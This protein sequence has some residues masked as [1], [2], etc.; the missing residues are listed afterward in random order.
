[1][2][3]N[4][5]YKITLLEWF[6]HN[7]GA[8]KSFKKTMIEHRLISDAKINALPL[9]NKWLFI[10]L[11]LI[12]GDH[13]NDTI[14]MTQRQVNE[15]LTT[16]EGAHNALD[17][18]QELRLLTFEKTSL[19]E[20]NK[21]KLS[22]VNKVK[23]VKVEVHEVVKN[24]L[25]TIDKISTRVSK[26]ESRGALFQ[27]SQFQIVSERL[28][29]VTHRA[30]E[31]WLA[32]YPSV[33]FITQEILRAHS[34]IETNPKKAPKNFGPFMGNWLS[35]AFENYRKG[36]PSRRQTQSEI[37]AQALQEMYEKVNRGE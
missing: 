28:R 2:A 21:E 1:M 14:T 36:I 12:C 7:P 8:Q 20:V 6:K 16:R 10:N 30:Q 4:T 26:A 33:E 19:I 25:V 3:N 13:A 17:R 27:F 18:M 37:N 24:G 29:D 5:M 31:G 11:I 22:K 23:E 9:S 35:R 32:A 34:W 15:I